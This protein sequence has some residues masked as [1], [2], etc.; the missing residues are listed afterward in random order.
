MHRI[1]NVSAFHVIVT[2]PVVL[3]GLLVVHTQWLG[4]HLGYIGYTVLAFY[5]YQIAVCVGLHRLWAHQSFK[6]HAAVEWVLAWVAAGSLQGPILAWASDHYK[7]HAFTDTPNDPHSPLKYKSRLAGFVW[8]HVGWMLYEPTPKKI[9]RIAL[10][11][12]GRNKPVMWQMK[13]YW[14]LAVFMNVIVPSLVGLFIEQTWTGAFTG[15]VF[16]GL[17]RVLQQHAT[18]TVNSLCHFFGR[19][20]YTPGTA[21][22]L[23]WGVF[24]LLGE[25]WHNFHH[26]FPRDYRNGHKW[27]HV[28]INKWIINGL[29]CVGLAWELEKTPRARIT[30]KTQMTLD[31]FAERYVTLLGALKTECRKIHTKVYDGYTTLCKTIG[32]TETHTKIPRTYGKL[33]LKS[34]KALAHLA[35]LRVSMDTKKL[36]KSL[37]K[38]QKRLTK[39]ELRFQRILQEHHVQ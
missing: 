8:S 14:S 27:Y 28:D 26:A 13:H 12:L 23:W 16:M 5:G 3:L 20:P 24:L 36:E 37:H 7:H 17:G 11:K 39:I 35:T 15:V 31:T 19:R 38:L 9:E 18:F 2:L 32:T 6:A 25:N 10:V 33:L 22:D 34:E 1:L 30:A 21:R 29:R 4:F